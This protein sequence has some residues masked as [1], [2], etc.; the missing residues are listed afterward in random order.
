MKAIKRILKSI[1]TIPAFPATGN[2]VAQLLNRPDYSVMQVANVIKYDP[3]ITA[4]ILKMA[5]SAYFGAQHKIS[6]IND[7]VMYLGQKN[8]L[9]A[10]QTAGVSKFYKK[11]ASGYFD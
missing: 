1:E 5:N 2:K 8:L 6:S 7:A 10:I 3:S 4:N 9:R 11:G